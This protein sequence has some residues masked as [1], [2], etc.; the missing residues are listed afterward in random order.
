MQIRKRA[1]GRTL[2]SLRNG[3]TLSACSWRAASACRFAESFASWMRAPAN[4]G[5]C[6]PRARH[7]SCI[8]ARRVLH[9][10]CSSTI[11]EVSVSCF[12]KNNWFLVL[13]L[14]ASTAG[15][16]DEGDDD[17]RDVDVSVDGPGGSA[18]VEVDPQTAQLALAEL[19]STV[20]ASVTGFGSVNAGTAGAPMANGRGVGAQGEIEVACASGGGARI[21]GRVNVVPVPVMV[22]VDVA[23][24]YAGCVTSGGTT[25]AGNVD[26]SQ[27]VAAGAGVPLRV[28]T[29]YQGDVVFSGEVNARC[30]VDL[31]V[32]VDETGRALQVGGSFCG[33]NATALTLQVNPRW[34]T[35]AAAR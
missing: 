34:Q 14:A 9:A 13:V 12:Q 31:N 5:V 16:N 4:N 35:G 15:C 19:A 23:I 27:S 29:L 24:A 33:Q 28:E 10:Q 8:A 3:R 32:L 7:R 18:S 25:I 22:D 21:A 6:R 2:S 17:T 11:E 1:Q 26:F 20:D 30:A